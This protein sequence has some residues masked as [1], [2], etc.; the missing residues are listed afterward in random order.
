MYNPSALVRCIDPCSFSCN[1]RA[2]NR[3]LELKYHLSKRENLL[4]AQEADLFSQCRLDLQTRMEVLEK[5]AVHMEQEYAIQVRS[6]AWNILFTSMDTVTEV[7]AS[8]A[9][10]DSDDTDKPVQDRTGQTTR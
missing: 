7:T 4:L 6:A 10:G 5:C 9:E 2:N 8:H 1:A 3:D